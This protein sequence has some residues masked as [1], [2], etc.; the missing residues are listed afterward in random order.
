MNTI[1]PKDIFSVGVLMTGME[2]VCVSKAL[3]SF[4]K[5][6]KNIYLLTVAIKIIFNDAFQFLLSLSLQSHY[7]RHSVVR[8]FE[9]VNSQHVTILIVKVE[10]CIKYA[11]KHKKYQQSNSK[12][13]LQKHYITKTFT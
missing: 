12:K 9:R 1:N 6:F 4:V 5:A 2:S 11:C 7:R 10:T 13:Y 3:N 8:Y